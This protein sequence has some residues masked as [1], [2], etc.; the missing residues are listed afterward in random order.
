MSPTRAEQKA[1]TRDAIASVARERFAEVGFESTTIRDIASRAG[2]SVG[3][4]H[5]HFRDKRALLFACFYDNIARAVAHGWET[6]DRTAPLVDQLV[7]LSH[8]LFESYAT[9]PELS[10]VM[11][12]ESV[13]REPGDARDEALEPFLA[14]VSQLFVDA[15]ARGEIGQLPGEGRREAE[16]FFSIYMSALIGGLNEHFGP[17]ESPSAA[18]DL[19]S[20][21]VRVLMGVVVSGLGTPIHSA[22]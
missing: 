4:V 18:A 20:A 1:A 16:V 13:F 11:F 2:V 17:I 6:L 9:H 3:S 5:V 12:K 14:R 7:H 21:Q 8:A 10:R 15:K 22:P 19:W